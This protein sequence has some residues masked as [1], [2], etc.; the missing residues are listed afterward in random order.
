MIAINTNNLFYKILNGSEEI[1][2]EIKG[3]IFNGNRPLDR[4]A[5]DICIVQINVNN[6][7]PQTGSTDINIHVPDIDITSGGIT[8]QVPDN[9]RLDELSEIVERVVDSARVNGFA[10][11]VDSKSVIDTAIDHYVTLRLSWVLASENPEV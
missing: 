3:E 2:S 11:K 1:T 4:K 10:F 9:K 6:G 7:R 5:E 8:Q